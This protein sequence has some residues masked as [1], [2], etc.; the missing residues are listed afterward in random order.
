[1]Q[2]LVSDILSE[3][4]MA[5]L[6]VQEVLAFVRPVRLQVARTSLSEAVASAVSLANSGTPRGAIQVN[7]D[8]PP[9]LPLI[10]LD[11]HQLTQVFN[12][13]LL[14]DV[15]HVLDGRGQV[16]ITAR[17]VHRLE[18]KARYSPRGGT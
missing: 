8:I 7:V 4:K 6:I 9:D 17:L 1:M 12:E 3:A 16:D 15:Y 13:I 11:Y 2:S 14:D 18:K 5:N 10:G